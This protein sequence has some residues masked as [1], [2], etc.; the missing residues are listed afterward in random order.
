V[1]FKEVEET[2]EQKLEKV[3]ETDAEAF[4]LPD[5][6]IEDITKDKVDIVAM[7][8][9]SRKIILSLLYI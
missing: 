9:L 2:E 3:I 7:Q 8:L 6:D 1:D 5:I 4:V